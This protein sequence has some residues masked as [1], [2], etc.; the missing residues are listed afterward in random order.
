MYV[1]F[2]VIH[3]FIIGTHSYIYLNFEEF[4][5]TIILFLLSICF[6]NISGFILA[7]K[8]YGWS[9]LIKKM[10]AGYVPLPCAAPVAIPICTSDSIMNIAP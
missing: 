1:Y 4:A 7:S 2:V 5:E 6:V 3:T 9:I 8:F 10:I